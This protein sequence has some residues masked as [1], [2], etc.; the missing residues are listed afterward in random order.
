MLAIWTQ[1]AAFLTVVKSQ[2]VI[3]F[4]IEK[5]IGQTNSWISTL[6]ETTVAT[7]TDNPVSIFIDNHKEYRLNELLL[8]KS[9]SCQVCVMFRHSFNGLNLL[10]GQ[11]QYLSD[12][13]LSQDIQLFILISDTVVMN[14][15][16][17]VSFTNGIETNVLWF[18][19]PTKTLLSLFCFPIPEIYNP[20][21]KTLQINLPLRCLLPNIYFHVDMHSFFITSPT[22]LHGKRY[23]L[24]FLNHFVSSKRRL[25]FNEHVLVDHLLQAMNTS[26][27]R[28]YK[29]SSPHS[30]HYI[31]LFETFD[32]RE[33]RIDPL[34]KF[35]FCG[36]RIF[37][38][39]KVQSKI[40][41]V[42]PA[43]NAN[44]LFTFSAWWSAFRLDSWLGYLISA[45]AVSL[46]SS[47]KDFLRE[48]NL[49]TFMRH[50]F[51]VAAITVRQDNSSRTHLL[52][53]FTIVVFLLSNLYENVLTSELTVH[54]PAQ[55]IANPYDLLNLNYFVNT[56]TLRG[57]ILFSKYLTD[58]APNVN[59]SSRINRGP[60]KFSLE[61]LTREEIE[62][63]SICKANDMQTFGTNI[64]FETL[65]LEGL[66]SMYMLIVSKKAKH[67]PVV[68]YCKE[69]LHSLSRVLMVRSPQKRKIMGIL[70]IF[71]H[72][73]LLDFWIRFQKFQ[74]RYVSSL[75]SFTNQY[76][77]ECDAA[78]NKVLVFKFGFYEPDKTRESSDRIDLKALYPLACINV[79]GSGCLLGAVVL[80]VETK[81][82][83]NQETLLQFRMSIYLAMYKF[84]KVKLLPIFVYQCGKKLFIV[85]WRQ[86]QAHLNMRSRKA[87]HS[88]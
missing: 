1:L 5:N 88:N 65:T 73:G 63:Q 33:Y 80:I 75:S 11:I 36:A 6:F 12:H 64:A 52:M 7:Q 82:L 68:K 35:L 56:R 71:A 30:T 44:Q 10:Q 20:V 31:G 17:L 51:A 86:L 32:C 70:S 25:C 14:P 69:E 67:P 59:F 55:P 37:L 13:Y 77:P 29:I 42:A 45:I 40:Y 18:T 3:N 79:V 66:P 48:R 87:T 4:N 34:N 49:L 61:P 22:K 39:G 84:L 50:V 16:Q 58:K 24:D 46:A 62:L 9:P 78:F 60:M 43:E 15:S 27:I 26:E 54:F 28:D 38:L 85:R 53:L 23:C 19:V 74:T 21:L 2:C 81:F 57:T 47:M 72:A 41:Y 83:V 76:S 8:T